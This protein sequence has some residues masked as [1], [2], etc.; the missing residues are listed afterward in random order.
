MAR[1]IDADGNIIT[2]SEMR[3]EIS[4]AGERVELSIASDFTE[5]CDGE[6]IRM[7]SRSNLGAGLQ[8]SVYEFS[9]DSVCVRTTQNGRTT[10]KIESL[11]SAEWLTP[12]EVDAFIRKRLA[13]GAESITYATLD[14]TAGMLV[15]QQT[16]RV[17]DRNATAE[18]NSET[19]DGV[20]KWEV[21]QNFM[22]D[23]ITTEFVDQQ[24]RTIRSQIPF[25]TLKMDTILADRATAMANVA[26]PEIMV[27]TLVK[28]DRTI[29]NPRRARRA[30][31]LVSVPDG[32]LPDLPEAAGQRVKRIDDATARVT[33][34]LEELLI[35]P[36]DNVQNEA[37]TVPSPMIDSDDPAIRRLVRRAD[38]GRRLAPGRA[39]R[40]RRYVFD[41]IRRKN[42]GVGFA[43][44]SE[45]C[46]SREGDCSE[47]AVLLAAM[48]R[49]NDIPS[50]VASGVLYIDRFAGEDDIFGYHMWT[51]AL[52]EVDGEWR[53]V[54]L[55]ATL[56]SSTPSDATHIAIVYTSLAEGDMV[57]SMSSIATLMGQLQIKVES[58]KY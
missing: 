33:I 42:L 49:A 21:T 6:P 5:T 47:H 53:W 51:Q 35:A 32:R 58:V 1:S 22:P 30:E 7:E 19:H 24:G 9:E 8:T 27:S 12:A 37:F 26:A 43:S 38:P 23:V 44:A 48:L 29:H 52:L 11:P 50:R 45:V 10:E 4:R 17:V 14:P 28:P 40:L 25:G 2:A 41:H 34:D 57:T 46:R 31:Y 13:A 39:E 18:A 16:H 55:D 3:F 56:P 15:F 20:I 36:D 54:D